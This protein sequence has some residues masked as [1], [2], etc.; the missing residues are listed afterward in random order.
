MESVDDG[1]IGGFGIEDGVEGL[2]EACISRILVVKQL[3]SLV[4]EAM[5]DTSPGNE[6]VLETGT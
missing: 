4:S 2:I 5:V 3:V 1:G 6:I